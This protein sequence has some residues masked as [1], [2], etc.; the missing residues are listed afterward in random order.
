MPTQSFKRSLALSAVEVEWGN[1]I[2]W[3]EISPVTQTV[4]VGQQARFTVNTD[5]TGLEIDNNTIYHWEVRRWGQSDYEPLAIKT[6]D[7]TLTLAI[8]DKTYGSSRIRCTVYEKEKNGRVRSVTTD[9]ANL[10]IRDMAT[11]SLSANKNAV[12]PGN[13][14]KLAAFAEN[15]SNPNTFQFFISRDSGA[16]WNLYGEQTNC[17][18]STSFTTLPLTTAD[19]GAL[20]YCKVTDKD[21][22]YAVSNAIA[23]RIVPLMTASLTAN[24]NPAI[25]L[26]DNYIK[27][28]VSTSNSVSPLSFTWQTKAAGSSTWDDLQTT[29]T[30]WF[31]LTPTVAD[32]GYSVRCCVQ[33]ANQSVYTNEIT[34][35]VI[36]K[37]SATI[38]ANKTTLIAGESAVFTVTP[39][40]STAP[41][42]YTWQSSTDGGA[43]FSTLGTTSTNTYSVYYPAGSDGMLV[44]CRIRDA[45]GQ[46]ATSNA[47]A[48]TVLPRLTA[49]I[50][51]VNPAVTEGDSVTFTVLP[52]PGATITGCTWETSADGGSTWSPLANTGT[53]Y[54]IPSVTLADNGLSLRAN[55]TGT[56][57]TGI[58][59]S[60][61]RNVQ[62]RAT[63][64]TYTTNVTTLTVTPRPVPP[65][66]NPGAPDNPQ[67]IPNKP[68]PQTGDD[69]PVV[70]LAA[71]AAMAAACLAVMHRRKRFM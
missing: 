19:N 65:Q 48:M 8:S 42:S 15:V 57:S 18:A 20:M 52:G 7:K 6:G 3:P 9:Y 71:I 12:V 68:L 24:P 17:S 28:T 35:T 1:V 70:L 43:T 49:T 59:F 45:S 54:T 14:L 60:A 66:P 33:D 58:T 10:Y 16:T 51:P 36:P 47:I 37:L 69:A 4:D 26:E 40:N 34:V 44:R 5:D 46:M 31:Y 67:L 23:V 22:R 62:P 38:S 61:R 25:I 11:V 13:T 2:V 39:A 50:S 30:R 64:Q 21:G 63:E 53:S 41:I 55:I 32:N 29:S 56:T 27:L